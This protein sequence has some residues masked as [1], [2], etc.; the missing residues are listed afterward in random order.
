V[1]YQSGSIDRFAATL[2]TGWSAPELTHMWGM[3]PQSDLWLKISPAARSF[4]FRI[5]GNPHV[6]GGAQRVVVAINGS[7]VTTASTDQGR[8]ADIEIDCTAA[9]WRSGEINHLVL[10]PSAFSTPPAGSG[11]TRELSICLW[12]LAIA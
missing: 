1:L 6:A 12:D 5:S 3:G 4:R 9:P 8:S 7:P 10:R 2:G 11:D